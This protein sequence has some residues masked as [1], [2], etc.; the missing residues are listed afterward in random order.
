MGPE[1]PEEFHIHLDEKSLSSSDNIA[2]SELP[3]WAKL[4]YF[5]CKHCPLNQEEHP[6]C[7]V[8][9]KVFQVIPQFEHIVSHDTVQLDVIM[10]E[11][12]VSMEST[13]QRA[14]S[15]MLGLMFATSGCPHMAFFKPMARFHLP[16]S[17]EED[18]LFRATGM[19]L[20]AQFFL[21]HTDHTADFSMQGLKQI[22]ENIHEVNTMV[23]KRIRNSSDSDTSANA[24]VLL[25]MFTNLLPFAIDDK[26]EDLEHLF[27]MYLADDYLEY[28]EGKYSI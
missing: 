28:I 25:D 6:Y 19:Y 1:E 4:N 24:I 15:S 26:L 17:T 14:I 11:R 12:T 5:Q 7:P 18:T 21:K 23:A 2:E 20:L 3:D 22:Y 13:A 27:D 16:L 10:S 8:A 9:I